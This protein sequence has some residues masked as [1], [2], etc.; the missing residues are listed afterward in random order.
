MEV[1]RKLGTWYFMIISCLILLSGIVYFVMC[2][3]EAVT[4][5]LEN[6]IYR[7]N[8]SYIVDKD[9][10]LEKEVEEKQT[11]NFLNDL[12]DFFFDFQ[13]CILVYK[14]KDIE[15]VLLIVPSF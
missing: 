4:T 6:H 3:I 2:K 8:L 5:K 11:V 12:T 1:K 9:Y 15:T 13:S 10:Y 14:E 7:R